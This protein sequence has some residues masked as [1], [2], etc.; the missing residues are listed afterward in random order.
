MSISLATPLA[1]IAYAAASITN[2]YTLAGSFTAGV[3][4]MYIISTLD[5]A[6]QISFNGTT[7]HIAVPPGSTV[8]AIIPIEFRTNQMSFSKPNIF[9]KEIGN[10]TTGSLYVCAFMKS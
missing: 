5:T 4:M 10:P 8:P 1:Q 6:V 7:D 3:D 2:T 9:V